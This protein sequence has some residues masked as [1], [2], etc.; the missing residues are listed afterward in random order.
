MPK[1]IKSDIKA[2][3]EEEHSI[4]AASREKMEALYEQTFE[5][6]LWL[7]QARS[8]ALAGIMVD[9]NACP[10]AKIEMYQAIYFKKL[11]TEMSDLNVATLKM[12]KW[13][14]QLAAAVL[15]AKSGM[16]ILENE[17]RIEDFLK[18]HDP[19]RKALEK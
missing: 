16:E 19:L 4:R 3:L 15:S 17:A 14:V 5:L 12:M 2:Q 9:V 10:I 13:F 6:E 8:K 7:E 1:A 11:T 18:F